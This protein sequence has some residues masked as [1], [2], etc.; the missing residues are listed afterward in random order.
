MKCF[1]LLIRVT[2]LQRNIVKN[3]VRG[4]AVAVALRGFVHFQIVR[5]LG[6][7]KNK[8][9]VVFVPHR[10][11][12]RLGFRR[13]SRPVTPIIEPCIAVLVGNDPADDVSVRLDIQRVVFPGRAAL[14]HADDEFHVSFP[15]RHADILFQQRAVVGINRIPLPPYRDKFDIVRQRYK[16]IH[17]RAESKDGYQSAYYDQ[18]FNRVHSYTL[19]KN[20]P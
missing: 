7:N 8:Q 18:F 9:R 13:R 17:Q 10:N 11:R 14:R 4:H 19:P 2:I 16:K 20:T 15:V 3:I 1:Q 12:D 5:P 6:R